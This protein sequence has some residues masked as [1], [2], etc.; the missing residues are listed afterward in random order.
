MVECDDHKKDTPTKKACL[1]Q[2]KTTA[3]QLCAVEEERDY[4]KAQDQK[5]HVNA[6]HAT[7]VLNQT[8]EQI[9]NEQHVPINSKV[10]QTAALQHYIVT[11][12]VASPNGMIKLILTK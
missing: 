11:P 1:S 2:V 8:F 3:A 6:I 5:Y 4:Y 7:L 12:N 9:S 10:K